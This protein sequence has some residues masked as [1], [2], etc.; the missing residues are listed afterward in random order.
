MHGVGNTRGNADAQGPASP[1]TSS[2]LHALRLVHDS[3][4]DND[5][6]RKAS[7]FLDAQKDIQGAFRHGFAVAS[8]LKLEAMIRHFGLSL[9]E[10]TLRR[11][12]H[13]LSDHDSRQLRE[14][15]VSL[16]QNI[17][18]EDPA[19]IRNKVAQLW[20]ELAKKSWALDWLDM[21]ACL[22]KLW[23]KHLVFK[24]LVLDI[25]EGLSED[26]FTRDDPGAA[27]RGQDL[28]NALVEIFTPMSDYA[29][30]LKAGQTIVPL[31]SGEDGW[32]SRM[33]LFL[34]EC[35]SAHTHS[36][37]LICLTKCLAAMRSVISWIMPSTII[38]SNSFSSIY[39]SFSVQNP[40]VLMVS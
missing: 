39:A 1:D 3:G 18:D 15:I 6:R 11:K 37:Y 28:H 19:Y 9:L 8:D 10:D 21:D 24:E 38:S 25:L 31:R 13:D 33:S 4:T 14:W 26:A 16:A 2:I 5:T 23:T 22:L 30:S 12:W 40:E 7:D 36:S 20:I 17:R 34:Q 27:I 29:G 32:L 35:V